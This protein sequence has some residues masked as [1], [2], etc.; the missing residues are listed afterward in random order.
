[1][2]PLRS[3]V[4]GEGP[5]FVT[6]RALRNLQAGQHLKSVIPRRSGR[7]E[8][9]DS[10]RIPQKREKTRTSD[11]RVLNPSGATR[12][13]DAQ[14]RGDTGE[15]TS[16]RGEGRIHPSWGRGLVKLVCDHRLGG[17]ES[18]WRVGRAHQSI[19]YG[20]VV[21]CLNRTTDDSDFYDL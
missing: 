19:K 2:I 18:H 5:S 8:P 10:A 12:V 14:S 17:V 15:W 6:L 21:V 1:M 11:S 13:T 3:D 9:F 7:S 16:I 4:S 20:R